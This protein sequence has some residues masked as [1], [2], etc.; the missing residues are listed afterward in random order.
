[1][2]AQKLD[3]LATAAAIKAELTQRVA[4]LRADGV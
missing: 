3:G 4:A 2:T 1:M